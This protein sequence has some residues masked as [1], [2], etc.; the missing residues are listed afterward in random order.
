[1][2]NGYEIEYTMRDDQTLETTVMY[3]DGRRIAKPL[4]EFLSED[5]D[6]SLHEM[7]KTN[8]LTAAR[9]FQHRVEAF[10][11]EVMMGGNN[12][13]KIKNLSYRV[14]FQGR[15]AAH[16]HGT[17]WLDIKDIENSPPFHERLSNKRNEILSSGF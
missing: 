6:E 13:M 15:G 17:L 16:I 12:P 3:K 10:K 4:K 8:V 11:K 5:V 2:E 9:N 14:E 7:I 1:M